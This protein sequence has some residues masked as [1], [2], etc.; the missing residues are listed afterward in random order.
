MNVNEFIKKLKDTIH[1][2]GYKTNEL[3]IDSIISLSP[4]QYD[5]YLYTDNEELIPIVIN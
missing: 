2:K 4:N 5:V 1:E 3:T